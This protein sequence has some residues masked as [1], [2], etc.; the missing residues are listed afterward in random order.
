MNLAEFTCVVGL[1]EFCASREHLVCC[2][3]I[4][5]NRNCRQKCCAWLL[6]SQTC[7]IVPLVSTS[8]ITFKH[9]VVKCFRQWQQSVK[10]NV[11]FFCMGPCVT[12]LVVHP[13][14]Q[15]FLCQGKLQDSWKT[16]V[17]CLKEPLSQQPELLPIMYLHKMVSL[18]LTEC[19]DFK[20][21]WI[22][23]LEAVGSIQGLPAP[24][25]VPF[26]WAFETPRLKLQSGTHHQIN[27]YIPYSRVC[28]F[29][30]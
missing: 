29:F 3:Q 16:H 21:S 20:L 8:K 28:L 22:S 1:P 6:Y 15:R 19:T 17:L 10:S 30:S 26:W 9:K 5:C 23:I 18:K 7:F 12:A 14:S 25:G 4:E 2:V 11:R 13:W 27:L 24:W